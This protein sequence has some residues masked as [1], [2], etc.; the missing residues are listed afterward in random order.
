M[1]ES[2]GNKFVSADGHVQEPAN[3]WVERMDRRFR[4][5]APRIVTKTYSYGK[6]EQFD[7]FQIEGLKSVDF[8]DTIATMAN[9]KAAGAPIEGHGH[10]RIAD[11][12]L[13]AGDPIARLADQDLDNVR[14]DTEIS[15]EGIAVPAF[16]AERRSE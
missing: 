13:G 3:L 11:V 16:F 5:R 14:A 4:D 12:R 6:H 8:I 9:E 15:A 7:A 2:N 10:N 1:T